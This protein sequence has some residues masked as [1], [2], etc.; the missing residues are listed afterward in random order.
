MTDR[1][2]VRVCGEMDGVFCGRDPK[3]PNRSMFNAIPKL[4]SSLSRTGVRNESNRNLIRCLANASLRAGPL[5]TDLTGTWHPAD[6]LPQRSH[7][8]QPK[9]SHGITAEAIHYHRDSTHIL[10]T[11]QENRHGRRNQDS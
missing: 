4:N 1:V 10:Y 2:P 9:L 11:H 5:R 3:R 6:W 7:V 8:L